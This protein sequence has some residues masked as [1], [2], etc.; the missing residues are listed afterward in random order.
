MAKKRHKTA[1]RKAT[2]NLEKEGL[3]QCTLLYSATALA[4]CRHWGKGKQ[5][6]TAL[7]ELSGDIWRQCAEDNMHSMIELCEK[8]TGIEIQNNS[9]KSWRELMYLNAT[10]DTGKLSNAQWVYMRHRQ[11]DW[12]AAQ[13]MACIMVSLHRKYGFGFDRCARIYQQIRDIE[14]EYNFEEKKL[15]EACKAETL[16]NVREVITE[17]KKPGKVV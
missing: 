2:E 13:V 5:A 11:K 3:K 14:A 10:L 1:Y 7:F 4:L 17:K 12:T 15:Q 6:I 9:G 16:I 8:E